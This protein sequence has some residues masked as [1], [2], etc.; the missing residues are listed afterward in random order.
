MAADSQRSWD[1]LDVTSGA[2]VSS[3]SGPHL[4]GLVVKRTVF[5]PSTDMV[6]SPPDTHVIVVH[7]SAPI[8]LRWRQGR[9]VRSAVV[10]P[11]HVLVNPADYVEQRAW[12]KRTED[13]RVGL[14]PDSVFLGSSIPRL[15]PAIG[16]HDPLLAQ[17]LRYLA[18]TF[19][20]GGSPDSLYA[21]A[22]AH[23]LGAHLVE[24]YSDR[25]TAGQEQAPD[26]MG[27][28][29]LEHVLDYIASN[30]HQALTVIELAAVAGVSPTHF[31]RLFRQHTGESPY[32]YVRN[33]RLDQ[34]EGLIIGTQLSFAAIAAAV[35]F[36]DQSHLN[37]VMRAQRGATP[38]QLRA[39][40]T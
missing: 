31:S 16:V 24:H 26:A 18:R 28:R 39:S 30:L 4:P 32:R 3:T 6:R 12:D 20:V 11:G 8:N 19:E 38:G 36:S 21:H 25:S 33:R 5:E 40:I 29:Q 22:L 9:W 27:W 35:G 34:A 37:R 10:A 14:A 17:L 2:L 13:V 7:T 23:A 15:R 1:E